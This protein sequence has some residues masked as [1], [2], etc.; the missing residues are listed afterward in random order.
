MP[1]VEP[2]PVHLPFGMVGPAAALIGVGLVLT[3]AGGPLYAYTERAS[4]ALVARTPY[5][6]AVLPDGE[7]GTGES[8]DNVSRADRGG[9]V[10][11]DLDGGDG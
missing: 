3:F 6:D 5:I 7:R 9:H 8:A 4:V 11:I 1:E 2:R 10:T